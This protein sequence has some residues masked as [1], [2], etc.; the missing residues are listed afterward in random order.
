M[1]YQKFKGGKYIQT[2]DDSFQCLNKPQT[3]YQD[4]I[5]EAYCPEY[6]K[7]YSFESDFTIFL[8]LKDQW[9]IWS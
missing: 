7:M 5:W 3:G 6:L 2:F 9:L 4:V 1:F 8:L